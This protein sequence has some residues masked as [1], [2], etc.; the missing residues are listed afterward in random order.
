MKV[1]FDFLYIIKN[2]FQD[3]TADRKYCI[4]LY[5]K[6]GGRLTDPSTATISLSFVPPFHVIRYQ[7][8]TSH[9]VQWPT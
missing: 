4:V 3:T 9:D 2:I 5:C 1:K 6:R 8:L 7:P